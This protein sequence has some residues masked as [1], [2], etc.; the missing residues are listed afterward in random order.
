[1]TKMDFYTIFIL[2]KILKW[3][4]AHICKKRNFTK[5]NSVPVLILYDGETTRNVNQ[6][7]TNFNFSK[8]DFLLANLDANTVT[9]PKTQQMDTI[10]IL[11]CVSRLYKLKTITLFNN[12][13]KQIINCSTDN[14]LV[15]LKELYKRLIVPFYIPIL[16]LT[17]YL[18]IFTSKENSNY[19]K[20][21]LFVFLIGVLIVIFS[22][23]IIRFVSEELSG[24]IYILFSPFFIFILF[25][26]SFISKLYSKT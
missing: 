14:K 9:H 10:D 8:S 4:W 16:M 11:L 3:F 7:F 6:K 25:Y 22:E 19:S 12:T 15:L 24:N 17:P 26:L 1:M 18:L 20:I 2:K 23:G 21:K 5:R 13:K